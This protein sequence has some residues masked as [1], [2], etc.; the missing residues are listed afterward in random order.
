MESC[1]LKALGCVDEYS[2]NLSVDGKQVIGLQNIRAG[3][4][5]SACM[6][7]TDSSGGTYDMDN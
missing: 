3:Y 4:T 5:E 6:R 2:G 1:E 7:C